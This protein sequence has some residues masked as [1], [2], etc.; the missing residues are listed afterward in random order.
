VQKRL[1]RSDTTFASGRISFVFM[2]IQFI[3][4]AKNNHKHGMSIAMMRLL[5]SCSID[6]NFTGRRMSGARCGADGS[7]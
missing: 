4:L 2:T 1:P 7:L 3:T 5:K 6:T